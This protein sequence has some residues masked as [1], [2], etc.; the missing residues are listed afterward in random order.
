[1]LFVTFD[2]SLMSYS[3]TKSADLIPRY[4]AI[5]TCANYILL[6][7]RYVTYTCITHDTYNTCLSIDAQITT[8]SKVHTTTT[9]TAT[10]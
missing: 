8:M 6:Y 5:Y 4:T 3:N 2:E 9:Y 10:S 7:T 1:M